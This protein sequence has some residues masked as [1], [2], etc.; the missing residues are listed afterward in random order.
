METVVGPA[1]AAP[2][3]IGLDKPGLS[4]RRMRPCQGIDGDRENEFVQLRTRDQG[5]RKGRPDR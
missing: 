4:L 5:R 2:T 1:S 3:D